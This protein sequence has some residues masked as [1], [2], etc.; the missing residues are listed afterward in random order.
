[1]A[2][3][4][5]DLTGALAA[6]YPGLSGGQRERLEAAIVRE[7]AEAVRQGH[8]IGTVRPLPDG[9]IEICRFTVGRAGG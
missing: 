1:M 5:P 8:G 3:G 4:Y 9:S 2:G 7:I 6:T